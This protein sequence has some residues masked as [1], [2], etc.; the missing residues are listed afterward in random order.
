MCKEYLS[1]GPPSAS[2]KTVEYIKQL[3]DPDEKTV[4]QMMRGVREG[5]HVRRFGESESIVKKG[6]KDTK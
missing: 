4:E 6:P 5:Y 1:R 3:T 2:V